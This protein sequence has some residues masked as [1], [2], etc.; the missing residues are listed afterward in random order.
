MSQAKLPV[1]LYFPLESALTLADEV[2]VKLPH[3]LIDWMSVVAWAELWQNP[4]DSFTNLPLLL[5]I[6]WSIL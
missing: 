2:A 6:I 5:S 1:I 3:P 4:S